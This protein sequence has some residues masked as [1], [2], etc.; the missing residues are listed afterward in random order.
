VYEEVVPKDIGAEDLTERR[1][2]CALPILG[3]YLRFC[4]RP[5]EAA[6]EGWVGDLLDRVD[7]AGKDSF[8]PVDDPITGDSGVQDY[9]IERGEFGEKPLRSILDGGEEGEIELLGV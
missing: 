8:G 6:G 5:D 4:N 2:W 9:Y 7:Y 1:F 3:W